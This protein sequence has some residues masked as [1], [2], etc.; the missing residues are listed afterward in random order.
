MWGSELPVEGAPLLSRRPLRNSSL[1]MPH[2]W[3][4]FYILLQPLKPNASAWRRVDVPLS[5]KA[6]HLTLFQGSQLWPPA[7]RH[8]QLE[9]RPGSHEAHSHWVWDKEALPHPRRWEETLSTP[10]TPPLWRRPLLQWPR[11]HISWFP[12]L[13]YS[14]PGPYGSILTGI[15]VS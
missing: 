4:F 1:K 12:L 10:A 7:L 15:F 8:F 5:L 6:V 2:Y 3:S 13:S 11:P 9:Y 14:P